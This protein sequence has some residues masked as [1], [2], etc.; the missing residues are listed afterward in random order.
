MRSPWLENLRITE[1]PLLQSYVNKRFPKVGRVFAGPYVAYHAWR[2]GVTVLDEIQGR[3]LAEALRD[4]GTPSAA[5]MEALDRAIPSLREKGF[6]EPGELQLDELIG[7]MGSFPAIQNPFEARA[8]LAEVAQ[9]TPKVV[10]EIGTAAGGMFYCLCQVAAPDALVVSIDIGDG[11]S[12]GG[13][14]TDAETRL[15]ETFRQRNQRLAFLRGSSLSH[16]IREQ[17]IALLGGQPI[18]VMFIDGDHNYGAVKADF[19]MYRGL[20][21]PGGIVGF[22]DICLFP[23]TH[24]AGLEVGILWKELKARG[25]EV[26]EFIESSGARSTA[27]LGEAYRRYAFL[28]EFARSGHHP[29]IAQYLALGSDF[30]DP[31]AVANISQII[32]RWNVAPRDLI[33]AWG[34]GIV[35]V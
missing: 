33:M 18:D 28:A 29:W 7:K 32:P 21:R 17:L 24:G 12:F 14:Q 4:P 35:Y 8:F 15:F 16:A 25:E 9:R 13:G 2:P 10:V 3:A 11:G 19:E 6:L 30:V 20:M 34:I 5:T 31:D 23:E 27:Q 26:R 22:H 1:T